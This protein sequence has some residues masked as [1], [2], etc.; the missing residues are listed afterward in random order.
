LESKYVVEVLIVAVVFL[1]LYFILVPVFE[2]GLIKY[3]DLKN[4]N[5]S[6]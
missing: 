3:I 5:E 2:G 1:I 4:K 6:V